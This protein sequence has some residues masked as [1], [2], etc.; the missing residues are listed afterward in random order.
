M[1]KLSD[2][3]CSEHSHRQLT[4]SGSEGELM[5]DILYNLPKEGV[6]HT[7]IC[8]Y[9]HTHRI[10]FRIQADKLYPMPETCLAMPR[11]LDLVE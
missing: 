5:A 9:G 7:F 11:L 2:L 10:I 8:E 3:G 4:L 1:L 6:F